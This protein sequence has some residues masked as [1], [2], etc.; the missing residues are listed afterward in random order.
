VKLA[1]KIG[2]YTE[3]MQRATIKQVAIGQFRNGTVELSTKALDVCH[4]TPH[5]IRESYL[6][7][8][9]GSTSIWSSFRYTQRREASGGELE[10]S[11][12]F[13]TTIMGSKRWLGINE[14]G[15]RDSSEQCARNA[16]QC[17]RQSPQCPMPSYFF[18]LHRVISLVW[19][20]FAVRDWASGRFS[21]FE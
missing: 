8:A 21:L 4:R 10:G 16:C 15:C 18:F 1:E 7:P 19:D 20:G 14:L 11:Y 9:L 12:Q 17:Q 2:N 13:S 6:A 3:L 5:I